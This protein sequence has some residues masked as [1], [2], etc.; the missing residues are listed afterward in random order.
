[1]V[2]F[3]DDTYLVEIR[4]A[5]TKRRIR[6]LTQA[7]AG[8]SGL[9][10]HMER[11]PHLTL[12]GPFTLREG[13]TGRDLLARIG[14]VAA[15]SGPV[16]FLMDGFELRQGMHGSVIAISVQPADSLRSLV[17]AIS[18]ALVPVTES[19]NPWDQTPEEK[20]YHV[21]LANRLDP[22]DAAAAFARVTPDGLQDTGDDVP[23]PGFL[24]TLRG[25]F[26]KTSPQPEG[27]GFVPPLLDETGLRITVMQGE[28]I[29]AEYD[30]F[31]HRWT[32][33]GHDHDSI[34]WQHTLQ[35]FRYSAGFECRDPAPAHPPTP[36]VISDLHLGHANIIHYCSR[37]FL[38]S[39]PGEMDH[40]LIKNWN[41]TISERDPIYH[42]GDLRYGHGASPLKEYRKRL[43][44]IVTFIAGNHDEG[45]PG[46]LGSVLLTHE[47]TE[48]LLI[49]DPAKAPA[50]FGGW[51]IHGHHHNNN[52]R[53]YPFICP[54]TRRINV[55]C[56][57]TGYTPVSLDEIV[58]RIR[59]L[60]TSGSRE[61]VLLRYGDGS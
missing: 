55:S 28:H 1:M 21:T 45:E 61:P 18:H 38:T 6:D 53:Q 40:V 2:S 8:A 29:F 54:R 31:E 22:E 15:L 17:A 14:A 50:S 7:V 34:S 16:P 37:P 4:L 32:M 57:V 27:P 49:H 10:A 20:W 13:T 24:G 42:L 12:F 19:L 44:G 47:G 5:R 33:T 60:E 25:M 9:T 23:Q 39:D 51:V 41:Y 36:F 58:R 30:F 43:H 3:S 56:E 59:S 46:S 52:L 35:A 26:K 11:H 48:F